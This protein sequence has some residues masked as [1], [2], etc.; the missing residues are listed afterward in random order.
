MKYRN[1]VQNVIVIAECNHNTQDQQNSL[2]FRPPSFNVHRGGRKKAI[3]PAEGNRVFHA[4]KIAGTLSTSSAKTEKAGRRFSVRGSLASRVFNTIITSAAAKVQEV[5][6]ARKPTA[7]GAR[8][9]CNLNTYR[10]K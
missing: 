2:N 10:K 9:V 7:T 4:W 8:H 1:S 6:P 5:V 3:K